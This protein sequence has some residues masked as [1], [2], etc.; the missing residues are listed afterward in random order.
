MS[1]VIISTCTWSKS[2][3]TCWLLY[4]WLLILGR[5]F[6]YQRPVFNRFSKMENKNTG[7]PT[8]GLEVTEPPI[9]TTAT[10]LRCKLPVS[11]EP[12]TPDPV[13]T[14]TAYMRVHRTEC[15][16]PFTK[17]NAK[18]YAKIPTTFFWRHCAKAMLGGFHF[19]LSPYFRRQG[20]GQAS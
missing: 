8:A 19:T 10:G 12:Q 13:R 18:C 20:A 2:H 9:V 17:L 5:R 11:Q 16:L 4:S 14:R 15:W 3:S 6:L 7:K 1:A